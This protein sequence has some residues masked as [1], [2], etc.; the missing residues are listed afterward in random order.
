MTEENES[1]GTVAFSDAEGGV[2][3]MRVR[4]AFD[5]GVVREIEGQ[6]GALVPGSPLVLNLRE[7]VYLS[8]SGV[9]EIVHLASRFPLVIAELPETVEKILR[10]AEVWPLLDVRPSEEEALTVSRERC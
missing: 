3:V 2:A 6:V 9:G 1:R 8:S 5:E 7:V 10:L 4:G